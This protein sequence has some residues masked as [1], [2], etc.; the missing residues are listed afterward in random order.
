M[1]LGGIPIFTRISNPGRQLLTFNRPSLGEQ[2]LETLESAP[3]LESGEILAQRGRIPTASRLQVLSLLLL[4]L[5]FIIHSIII[6]I[7]D[8]II[9]IITTIII[10]TIICFLHY[11]CYYCYYYYYY[12]YY[13]SDHEP[14]QSPR[15]GKHPMRHLR[16]AEGGDGHRIV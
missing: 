4:L 12:Y 1:N 10:T 7:I 3:E 15:A 8:I 2:K 5:L 9:I 16:W 6:I 13:Y 11:Y 14:A